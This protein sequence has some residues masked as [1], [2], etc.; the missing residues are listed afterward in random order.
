MPKERE[1]FAGLIEQQGE[2][3]T[4][5]L[6]TLGLFHYHKWDRIVDWERQNDGKP[7]TVEQ[8]YRIGNEFSPEDVRRYRQI[9]NR[10][11]KDL[12]QQALLDD[13]DSAFERHRE[14]WWRGFG[15]SFAAALAYSVLLLILYIVVRWLGS[16]L[17]MIVGRVAE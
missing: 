15:Q 13:L 16:D 7:L 6:L 5:V 12:Q 11:I 9:S 17:A 1:I 14:N 10:T 3:D 4:A 2:P 8:Q